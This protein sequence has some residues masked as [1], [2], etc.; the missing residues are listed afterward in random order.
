MNIPELPD[1]AWYKGGI[2]R[3]AL[4]GRGE[5][6]D[7][8]VVIF[9][10]SDVDLPDFDSNDVDVERAESRR[11]YMRTRDVTV[12][13]CLWKPSR[14]LVAS[15]EAHRDADADVCRPTEY[16]REG[17]LSNRAI[18]R[19]CLFAA[20]LGLEV[21][22][23]PRMGDPC[24]NLAITIRKAAE[25]E[26]VLAGFWSLVERHFEVEPGYCETRA[27][28]V[29]DQ[30]GPWNPNPEDIEVMNE[31]RDSARW[32][33]REEKFREEWEKFAPEKT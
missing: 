17:G 11:E 28:E 3:C 13:E 30:Y 9:G 7:I 22:D 12:N 24:F 27:L 8:D 6:R 21:R 19:V 14:G 29:W 23:V 5:I 10:D 33:E 2:A 1:G 15:V 26:A 18:A 16:E 25:M 20:R 31:L 32:F 4:L